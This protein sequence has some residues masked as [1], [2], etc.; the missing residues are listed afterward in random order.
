MTRR[1]LKL[2]LIGA[3]GRMGRELARAAQLLEAQG[4][5][6]VSVIGGM[7]AADD[8]FCGAELSGVEGVLAGK[9][10]ERFNQADV[11]I[12]F[13]SKAGTQRAVEAATFAKLPMVVG[14]TGLG[15]EGEES[16]RE[17]ARF[18]PIVYASNYSVAMNAL[19]YLS[20]QAAG[21]LGESY[22]AEIVELHHRQKKDAPSGSA[23][24]LAKSIAAINGL[25]ATTSFKLGRSGVSGVRPTG[26]IG[27]SAVRGGDVVGEHT[28]YFFG[29]G[30]RLE[31]KHCISNRA[32]FAQG[33]LRAAQWVVEQVP[34]LYSMQDVLGIP[35]D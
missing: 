25:D 20:A 29:P 12:D 10:E 6:K 35:R 19:F 34:G 16:L 31:L 2:C 11:L 13:S 15:V 28:V 4:G 7:V 30:E 3:S 21:I 17:A 27:I 18:I 14:T 8:P 1:T 9:W 32:I 5:P 23:L 24:S 26:E 22:D 33:A